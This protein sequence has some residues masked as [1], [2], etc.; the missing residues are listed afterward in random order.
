MHKDMNKQTKEQLLTKLRRR[1]ATAGRKHKMKLIDQAVELLGYHR[2]AAIRALDD[3][4]LWMLNA[5]D[6][7]THW[8]ELRAL[9][10]RGQFSTLEQLLAAS[11]G[12][13]VRSLIFCAR[14]PG[15][16]WWRCSARNTGC[17]GISTR[18]RLPT[19][20]TAPAACRWRN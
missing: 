5:G 10:N 6:I 2:K 4:H 15:S 1:Y 7:Q 12:T 14:R 11:T 16:S 8:I 3:K 13:G 20:P 9:A 19:P 18:R 17:A